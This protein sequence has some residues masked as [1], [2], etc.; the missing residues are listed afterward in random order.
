M[1]PLL[2]IDRLTI[3]FGGLTAVNNVSYEIP[4]GKIC[5]IIGPNGA[6]KTTVFNAVTG[7]YEPTT[8]EVKL[9]GQP[10]QRPLTR[11]AILTFAT[12]GLLTG[13][14]AAL[15]A[16]DVNALWKATIKRN[17]AGPEGGFSISDAGR[18]AVAYLLGEPNLERKSGGRWAVVT[19]DGSRELG[20]FDSLQEARNA[21]GQLAAEFRHAGRLLRVLLSLIVG[22]VL[23]AAGSFA[24]W[25]RSRRTADMIARRGI[26][27]TF[28]N[29]RLFQNMT[30]L[31]NVV[32]AMD[33]HC[34][35]GVWDMLVRSKALREEQS[36]CERRARELLG[37]VGLSD[38]ESV[39]AKNLPYGDQRRLEIARA[40]ATEPKLVLLDEPAAGMNPTESAQLTELIRKIRD[41]GYTV[42]LIEHHMKI[43]M[44]I[45]DRVAVL[46]YGVKIA[47]GAPEEV[48]KNPKVIE[49]YLGAES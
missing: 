25:N 32:T 2:E 31:E 11:K 9:S 16:T 45:S 30:V 7:I 23:G 26:A 5:A 10:L 4:P 34:Q 24:V 48:R 1:Q 40:L 20:T 37:F 44:G 21:R 47:E 35:C 42:L 39:V 33:R 17:Y 14:G 6:G 27:R 41:K 3:R 46:D 19:V 28:Q 22:T 13:L 18:D 43:V 15:A 49:A 29:I 12:I 38:R 8:G 36:S